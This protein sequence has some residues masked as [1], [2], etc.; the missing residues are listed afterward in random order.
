V[1]ELKSGAERNRKG[2]ERA[3][4]EAWEGARKEPG[5]EGMRENQLGLGTKCLAGFTDG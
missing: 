1:I 4:R 5:K 3:W 2:I